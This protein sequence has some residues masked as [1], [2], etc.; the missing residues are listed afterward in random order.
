[1][2]AIFINLTTRNHILKL[3]KSRVRVG[4][5]EVVPELCAS[6]PHRAIR[7]R[8]VAFLGLSRLGVQ[9]I[10][11][12]LGYGFAVRVYLG[13]TL[14]H[15]GFRTEQKESFLPDAQTSLVYGD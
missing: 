2:H 7:E 11:Y 8:H 14:T 4:E 3:L 13:S 9:G 5:V 10:A 12:C 6:Q 15:F 1:M